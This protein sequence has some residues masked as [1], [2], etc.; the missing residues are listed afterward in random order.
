MF[1]LKR[2]SLERF[3]GFHAVPRQHQHRGATNP[4][5]CLQVAHFVSND[6]R[7]PQVDL[8]FLRR[9]DQHPGLGLAAIAAILR[10]VGTIVDGIEMGAVHRQLAGQFFVGALHLRR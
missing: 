8:M 2:A 3:P 10:V 9:L 1:R 6:K 5:A 7:T 4:P